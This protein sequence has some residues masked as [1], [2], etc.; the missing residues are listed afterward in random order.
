M[1][2]P[3]RYAPRNDWKRVVQRSHRKTDMNLRLFLIASTMQF[4]I[5]TS[6]CALDVISVVIEGISDSKRDGEQKDYKEAVLDAKLKAIERAGVQIESSTRVENFV[7]KEDWIESK[8]EAVLLPGFEIQK[9]GYGEDRTTYHI[10]LIGKIKVIRPAAP[11]LLL[12][13]GQPD[14]KTPDEP[15]QDVAGEMIFVPAG[16]F[17]MGSKESDSN[18]DENE[19]PQHKISLDAF[20]IDKFEVTNKQYVDFIQKTSYISK[21]DWQSGY[22]LKR[23]EHPVTNITWDDAAAFCKWAGKRLPT[24]AEWEKAARGTD[25]RKYPWGNTWDEKRANL[26]GVLG[27]TSPVG[28]YSQ[29]AG[30]YGALQMA[31]NVWEWTASKYEPYPYR[32][33]GDREV[34]EGTGLRVLRG[35]SWKYGSIKSSPTTQRDSASV[36]YSNSDLGCRCAKSAGSGY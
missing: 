36:T 33:N 30:P 11:L 31:G 1:R 25:G 9:I 23:E 4:F 28:S 7:L 5:I 8:A 10:V 15:R 6:A 2:L 26:F 32:V 13:P 3:R 20:Y 17:L 16:P 24:E 19:T 29:G 14:F 22:S 27:T 34:L 21:G 12:Q 18:A 35:G